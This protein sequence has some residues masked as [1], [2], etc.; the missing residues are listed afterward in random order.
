VPQEERPAEELVVL[1]LLLG[2]LRHQDL[3]D[4]P[5]R[6]ALEQLV[7]VAGDPV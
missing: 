2:H 5:E 3:P 7:Q 6:Q 4:L 1:G